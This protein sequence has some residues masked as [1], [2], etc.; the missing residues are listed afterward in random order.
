MAP[1][2][3]TTDD[4][5]PG[6][7]YRALVERVPVVTYVE[8]PDEPSSAVFVA[9]QIEALLGVTPA[10]WLAR[11]GLWLELLHPEDRERVVA[12]HRRTN[13]TGD[14][15]RM[16]YRLLRPDREGPEGVVWVRD[17]A[18]LVRGEGGAPRYWHGVLVDIGDLKRA[19]AD[20]RA[21]EARHRALLENARDYITVVAADGTI[22]YQSPAADRL[23]RRD[24]A[25]KVGEH[26]FDRLH[27]DDKARL[28]PIFAALLAEPGATIEEEARFAAVDGGWRRIELVA[29]NLLHDPTL[30]GIVV[31]SRDVTETREATD[32]LHASEERLRLAL[33]NAAMGIWEWDVATGRVTWSDGMGPLYGLPAGTT[34]IEHDRFFAI[35]HPDDRDRVRAADRRHIADGTD[36]EVE[37][38]VVRPD[39]EVR[40]LE[41]KGRATGR[42]GHGRATRFLGVTLDVTDRKRAEA[43]LRESE[44]HARDLY[45][46]AGRHAQELA[47]LHEVRTALAQE[48]E[49]PDLFRT[50]VEATAATFGYSLVS[51]YLIEQGELRL[52]HQVGYHQMLDRLPLWRGVMGRVARTGRPELLQDAL[53]DADFLQAFAG[54][55]SEVCVPL[56]DQ[57]RVVGVLNLE[58]T[59]QARLGRDD[60]DLMLALGNYV[61]LAIGRA[62]LHADVC[63]SEARFRAA[64]DD[65][66]IGMALM[67]TDG[68]F[69]QVNRALCAMIGVDEAAL[70]AS[71][72]QAFTHPD[73][74]PADL[75]LMR[76]LL[77]GETGAGSR[78]KRY[79]HHR[80]HSL[81]AQ[82][83]V[84]LV[85]GA[86]GAPSYFICQIEDISA[87]KA[88]EARLQHLALHDPLTRLP[89]RTRFMDH[90][91]Q[92]LA[93]GAAG[94]AGDRV[95]VLF[96]DLDG[97]KLVNDSLGH[98][99]GDRL[100]IAAAERLRL[101]LR[102][103]D[104]IARLGGDEFA[105][106][107]ER[108]GSAA[109]ATRLAERAIDA[110]R[111]AIRLDGQETYVSASV[112]IAL[113]NPGQ[114]DATDLLRQADV[115][116]YRAKGAGRGT[117]VLY[118]P[119]MTAPILARLEQETAL[120]QAVERGELRLHYQP[121]IDLATGELAGLEALVHWEHPTLG[122]LPPADFIHLA[123][124][125]GVIVPLGRWALGE[126]CGRL[127][128]WKDRFPRTA[129]PAISVNLS[130]REFQEPDLADE[131]A[132]LLRE[133]GLAPADLELEITESVVMGHD[134]GTGSTIAALADLGVRLAIDDFGTGYSSLAYLADLPLHALKIDRGLVRRLPA[135][136]S[137]AIV[138]A[139]ATLAQDLAIAVTAEGIETAEQLAYLRDLRV[140]RGQ[141]FYFA[142]P[143]PA[144]AVD[145]FLRRP[146]PAA[147]LG[148]GPR[149][150]AARP[151]NGSSVAG[152]RRRGRRR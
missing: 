46:A 10:A 113:G 18:R 116:L 82:L 139:I 73:D 33:E 19:E 103:G 60:L 74:I 149:V 15:F 111:P 94:A 6:V 39:G 112:G 131:I 31:N 105:I 85:R 151:A 124:E 91:A 76:R 87:R 32:A 27:P 34:A 43:A 126:A 109:E 67:A 93:G 102:P 47:L 106:L 137:Q 110:L 135:A 136:G 12:E 114:A 101:C 5:L 25:G 7:P 4:I 141:G 147:A 86:K 20:L 83:N 2:V 55:T 70:L 38:R 108:V 146:R 140:H 30:T 84:S 81:W 64:F 54:L 42:D 123:E 143:L 26:A 58:T 48:L 56:H 97:F 145:G 98:A 152:G 63:R 129:P 13:E 75:E 68:R 28:A 29:T 78:E 22:R 117:S 92:T 1:R 107:A 144:E 150:L 148:T 71:T 121:E 37:F 52:Q 134:A 128:D 118:R 8:L 51:L 59:G 72:N 57:G 138:R 132:R 44:R 104:T 50:V 89:N 69:L 17:E 66:P 79:R 36:Y 21:N 80:G 119:A 127:R 96:L 100:L 65:A 133:T 130:F 77:A 90:L 24:A 95:A 120:Q 11:P 45:Q 49:L 88:L 40:W 23:S 14:P 62:R 53:A 99:A 125:T 142:P 61:D 3:S 35:L 115:A 9:P 41:G 16:E 122:L